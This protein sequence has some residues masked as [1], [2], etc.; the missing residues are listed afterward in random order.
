LIV[1]ANGQHCRRFVS[2]Y[3]RRFPFAIP[4]AGLDNQAMTFAIAMNS[5]RLAVHHQQQAQQAGYSIA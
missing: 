1:V 4:L 3:S 5:P 2:F